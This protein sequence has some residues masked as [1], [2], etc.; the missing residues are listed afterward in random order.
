LSGPLLIVETAAPIVAALRKAAEAVGAE[1]RP[2]S[3]QEEAYAA[4]SSD[5]AMVI[6]SAALVDAEALCKKVKEAAP[7]CPVVLVF[8]PDEADPESSTLKAGADGCLVGPLKHGV[9]MSC[10]RSML[11]IRDLQETVLKLE[12]DLKQRANEPPLSGTRGTG[13]T[14]FEFFKKTL[15]MEVKRSRRYRYPVT[16]LLVGIDHFREKVLSLE[17]PRQHAFLGEALSIVSQAVRDIDLAV[18]FSDGRFLVFLPHT[19]R[20]G[21]GVVATRLRERLGKTSLP[22]VTVSLGVAAYEPGQQPPEMPGE[23][24][25]QVSFGTLMKEASDA[26]AKA[27]LAGGNRVELGERQKRSRISLG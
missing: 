23:K 5:P 19:A 1:V 8:T 16:F 11:R 2:V 22:D 26:L 12:G 14:E 13:S 18:P 10:V 3:K 7:R 25:P 15:L 6:A 4:L 20:A 27:Q 17:P 9:V 21:A 24:Q